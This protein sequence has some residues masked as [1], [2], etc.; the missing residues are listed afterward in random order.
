[1]AKDAPVDPKRLWVCEDC[2]TYHEGQNPP[3]N[4]EHCGWT[5]FDNQ[6]DM[7]ARAA[8]KLAKLH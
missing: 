8:R 7:D 2:G 4:C 3:D 1:M 5:Y 6:H